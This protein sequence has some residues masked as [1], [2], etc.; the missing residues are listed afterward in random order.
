M[1]PPKFPLEICKNC[2]KTLFNWE[3]SMDNLY[4]TDD[5]DFAPFKITWTSDSISP[6]CAFCTFALY[7]SQAEPEY[8]GKNSENS[9]HRK[10][11]IEDLI[12]KT[13]EFQNESD[14]V[15]NWENIDFN[16]LRTTAAKTMRWSVY[17][18]KDDPAAEFIYH[19]PIDRDIGSCNNMD[20]LREKISFCE[21]KHAACPKKGTT[22][23]PTRVLDVTPD[24]K[25][26][27]YALRL[28]EF[29]QGATAAWATLSYVWGR[30]QPFM[31]VTKS[32]DEYRKG[33]D[34]ANLGQTIRD[35]ITVTR[36]LGL[37]YLWVD[38]LCIIQDSDDDKAKE[39]ANMQRNYQSAFIT[40]AA[41]SS[42]SAYEGFLNTK[43]L[44]VPN[45]FKLPLLLAGR[46]RKPRPEDIGIIYLSPCVPEEIQPINQRAWCMVERVLSPRYL[47][48]DRAQRVVQLHCQCAEWSNGGANSVNRPMQSYLQ[49]Q[50]ARVEHGEVV[51]DNYD[52]LDG[53]ENESGS[54]SIS[55]DSHLSSRVSSEQEKTA[56]GWAK[57]KFNRLS[58]S[59][60]SRGSERNRKRGECEQF[61]SASDSN[62]TWTESSARS[63]T[64]SEVPSHYFNDDK[65]FGKYLPPGSLEQ[66][67]YN[68]VK[69]YSARQLT[70]ARDKLPA[71]SGISRAY[72]NISDSRFAAGNWE[73]HFP[74]FL[75]WR[76]ACNQHPAPDMRFGKVWGDTMLYDMSRQGAYEIGRRP[77]YA[78]DGEQ[79][80]QFYRAPS[81]SW[82]SVDGPVVYLFE[83]D[84]RIKLGDEEDGPTRKEDEALLPE[85]VSFDIMPKYKGEICVKGIITSLPSKF[86]WFDPYSEKKRLAKPSTRREKE[87]ANSP[88]SDEDVTPEHNIKVK[89]GRFSKLKDSVKGVAKRASGNEASRL[90]S[91]IYVTSSQESIPKTTRR[92]DG[93]LPM[94][95]LDVPEEKPEE[96]TKVMCLIVDLP[97]TVI[98]TVGLLLVRDNEDSSRWRRIGH[99]EDIPRSR[100]EGK[101]KRLI[102]II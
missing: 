40:I 13:V 101:K 22:E 14:G 77:T 34:E 82:V 24:E 53:S 26:L 91:D 31:T 58:R 29:E 98:E 19:R 44:P 68:I 67:W 10:L 35:A 9:R 95:Y 15:K 85:L 75:L 79:P 54:D 50:T 93:W 42:R 49:R 74:R 36:E 8:P 55:S 62:S 43:D 30:S 70:D 5:V 90:T 46:N 100:F 84:L 80:K 48:F 59:F 16:R 51:E 64:G 12:G 81:W 87:K 3:N 73:A 33:I 89:A 63:R 92:G 1:V 37:R 99:F 25:P 78:I 72:Q 41:I 2:K 27:G 76:I 17:A 66:F 4:R 94:G 97:S 23:V 21:R 52:S 18:K 7:A 20:L 32:I 88:S 60:K 11:K 83:H 56:K 61:D 47:M 96:S 71:L 57:A 38:S 86:S 65:T 39:I 45:S 6:N 102:T 28:H 69:D